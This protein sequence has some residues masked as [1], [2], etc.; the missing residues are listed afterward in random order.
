MARSARTRF[1]SSWPM[2]LGLIGLGLMAID[3]ALS[4]Q[5]YAAW[6]QAGYL[7]LAAVMGLGQAWRALEQHGRIAAQPRARLWIVGLS[8]GLLG[9]YLLAPTLAEVPTP[10]FPLGLFF[11][12]VTLI[13]I[14]RRNFFADQLTLQPATLFVGSFALLI[15]LGSVALLLP[16]STH[17]PITWLDALFTATS[18]VCVTGLTVLDTGADFT[19]QGQILILLLIQLGGLGMMTFTSFFSFFFKGQTSIQERLSLMDLDQTSLQEMRRFV[20]YIVLFTLALEAFGG[21]MI[22]LSVVDKHPDYQDSEVFF[23]IFHS[24]SAFCNAGF[25]TLG[26]SLAEGS[27][28]ENYVLHGWV[29]LLFVLGGLGYFVTFGLMQDS[30][31]RLHQ[32]W[33]RW[34]GADRQ[35]QPLL[36]K[37]TRLNS[38]LTLVV[39]LLL[40]TVGTLVCLGLE[41]NGVLQQHEDLGAKLMTAFFT[42]ATPRT[43]GF[44][45]VDTAALSGG[46]LMV[47]IMLMWIGSGPG[48]TGGG[49]KTTTFA[50]IGLNILAVGRGQ[51][52]LRVAG[53]EVSYQSLRRAFAVVSLSLI[54][55][56]LGTLTI[57]LLQP[58]LRPLPILFECVSAYSTVGLSL[59]ITGE[60]GPG[61]RAVIIVLMFVGRVGALSILINLLRQVEVARYRLPEEDVFIN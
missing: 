36:R 53:R 59:G 6:F 9:Y 16:G 41:W 38:R 5:G 13:E 43:A 26:G 8:F 21:V 39:T 34:R 56:A 49:I 32:L 25:S 29:S 40:L 42:A 1:H 30:R 14:Q 57:A 35:N 60:L 51:A 24:I 3:L 45:T 31:E 10:R 17:Q 48:S 54:G 37:G 7:L 15:L 50:L 28:Q 12:A 27:F 52:R 23:A 4:W 11:L 47:T 2:V 33:S 19:L 44:N 18:A 61:S 58:E 20:I 46:M 55:M 22:W